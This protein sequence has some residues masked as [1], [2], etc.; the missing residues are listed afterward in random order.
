[1]DPK[2]PPQ[3]IDAE[4]SV[5]GALML[6]KNAIIQVADLITAEDFYKPS[7]GQIFET[8]IELFGN[9]LSRDLYGHFIIAR[10]RLCPGRPKYCDKTF[11]ARHDCE[12]IDKLSHDAKQ[13]P[14]IV[15]RG[16]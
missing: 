8:I 2:L 1:M 12:P 5:L 9:K 7:H 3:D 16:E 14:Y 13:T 6:D 4:R 15:L 11:L 10:S